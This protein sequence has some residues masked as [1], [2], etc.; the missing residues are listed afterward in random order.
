VTELNLCGFDGLQMGA[1][2]KRAGLSSG[3]LYNRFENVSEMAI[4]LWE[5][6]LRDRTFRLFDLMMETGHQEFY[7]PLSPELI[8]EATR[9]S[10]TWRGAL[11]LMLVARRVEELN[12]VLSADLRA[13]QLRNGLTLDEDPIFYCR[14]VSSLSP[15]IGLSIMAMLPQPV[16]L[17]AELV[18]RIHQGILNAPWEYRDTP[19]LPRADTVVPEEDLEVSTGDPT[20][21]ALITAAGQVTANAGFARATVTRIARLAGYTT[22]A[23]YERWANKDALIMDTVTTMLTQHLLITGQQNSAS[24]LDPDYRWL[25]PFTITQSLSPSRSLRRRLRQEMTLAGIHNIEIGEAVSEACET[26]IQEIL[27]AVSRRSDQRSTI[28]DVV[29]GYIRASVAGRDLLC[30]L[31]T[32]L[33]RADFRPYTDYL[34][35]RALELKA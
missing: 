4:S 14:A 19:S 9:P 28:P 30:D 23:I 31:D 3:A 12:E 6:S 25:V 34:F 20:V 29:A 33:Y 24:V 1:V 22:S 5:E 2:A 35:D 10:A 21:D 11:E 16:V 7:S 13:W 8:A 27:K 26:S 15:L 18:L 32:D 17:P